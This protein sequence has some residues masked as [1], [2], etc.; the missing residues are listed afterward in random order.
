MRRPRSSSLVRFIKD[1]RVEWAVFTMLLN[2][3]AI[4][5]V[6]FVFPNVSNLWVSVFVLMSGFSGSVTSLGDLLVSAEESDHEQV[7]KNNEAE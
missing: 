2:L 3:T 4:V 6:V 7:E 1:Y 5:T